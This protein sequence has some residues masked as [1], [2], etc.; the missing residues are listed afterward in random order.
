MSIFKDTFP[1]E[2]KEQIKRRQTLLTERKP[3][4]LS[5]LNSRKAWVRLTSGVNVIEEGGEGTINDTNTYASKYVL[6]GGTLD[7]GSLRQG[8]G[9]SGSNAYSTK[10]PTG[11]THKLGIRPMPG[12]TNV[13]IKSKSAYGSLREATINFICWDIAQLEDLE[14]LYMRPGFTAL[15]E[16][17]WTPYVKNDDSY[18]TTTSTYNAFLTGKTPTGDNALQEIYKTLH[19]TKSLQEANGNY[20]ALIGYIKNFQW[21]FRPDGGYDC[22]TTLISFGEVLESL[23]INYSVLNISAADK[24]KGFLGTGGTSLEFSSN[25]PKVY[26]KSKLSGLLYELSAYMATTLKDRT[27]DSNESVL[28]ENNGIPFS[29]VSINGDSYDMFALDLKVEDKNA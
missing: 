28:G 16:W 1:K 25:F 23:K 15:L 13:D 9:A 18:I 26:D 4:H 22:S 5:Y 27:S 6:Q 29:N 19:V 20:D 3:K 17:G 8:I 7:D 2:V 10:T 14:L 12:I 24:T 11:K 21:S